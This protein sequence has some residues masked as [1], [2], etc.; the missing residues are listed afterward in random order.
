MT[1]IALQGIATSSQRDINDAVSLTTT[2]GYKLELSANA[3]D[4]A[5]WAGSDAAEDIDAARARLATTGILTVKSE[6]IAKFTDGTE[7]DTE[8]AWFEYANEIVDAAAGQPGPTG[9]PPIVTLPDGTHAQSMER[10]GARNE[11]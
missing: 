8:R 6:T 5:A 7:G 9:E 10:P 3:Y 4:V 11:I 2:N 1:K